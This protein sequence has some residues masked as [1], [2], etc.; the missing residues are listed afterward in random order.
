MIRHLYSKL[1]IIIYIL[2]F[3]G[4]GIWGY[5]IFKQRDG[6]NAQNGPAQSFPND[7]SSSLA[8]TDDLTNDQD[9]DNINGPGNPTNN[10]ADQSISGPVTPSNISN[11]D[12]INGP[13]VPASNIPKKN[14]GAISTTP[15]I[16]GSKLANITPEQCNNDCQAFNI[17]LKLFEYCEESC[18]ISPIQN[19]ASCDDKKDLQKD[20][21]LKDLAITKKD[22][23][24]CDK[25]NDANIKQAC[26]SR[27]EQDNVEN[28]QLNNSPQSPPAF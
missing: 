1:A 2:A 25:I 19:V 10:N 3:I 12:T 22:L 23:P 21:C 4:L 24:S 9:A 18:G 14:P 5:M 15:N 13:G 8:S 17:D 16:S 11:P 28:L 26:K 6:K 7:S 27:I 20:Y